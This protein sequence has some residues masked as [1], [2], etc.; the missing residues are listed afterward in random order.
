MK[1][2]IRQHTEN[3]DQLVIKARTTMIQLVAMLQAMGLDPL[4]QI[5]GAQYRMVCVDKAA[6][7]KARKRVLLTASRWGTLDYEPTPADARST[8]TVSPGRFESLELD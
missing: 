6:F 3:P 7:L 8:V 2:K 1:A 5:T 4:E